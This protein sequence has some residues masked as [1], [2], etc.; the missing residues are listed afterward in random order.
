MQ[1]ETQLGAA[2]RTKNQIITLNSKEKNWHQPHDAALQQTAPHAFVH[3]IK[4]IWSD[5]IIQFIK[6]DFAYEINN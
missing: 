4:F 6:H 2:K 5:I 3:I 1:R